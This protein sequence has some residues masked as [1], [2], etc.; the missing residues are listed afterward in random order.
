MVWEPTLS[1]GIIPT[2]KTCDTPF[3]QPAVPG[4]NKVSPNHITSITLRDPAKLPQQA[5][6]PRHKKSTLFGST[7]H[8]GTYKRQKRDTS[9]LKAFN[10]KYLGIRT[11]DI[12][13]DNRGTNTC[14]TPTVTSE[15][16][17][18]NLAQ[19]TD[20]DLI[21]SWKASL[22]TKA[23][24]LTDK[25]GKPDNSHSFTVQASGE[26][27]LHLLF[28][29]GYLDKHTT[30]NLHETH[31]LVKHLDDMRKALSNYDFTWIRDIDSNWSAQTTISKEKSRAMMACLLH[32][33]MDISLLMRYLGN[34]YT[35]A[36]RH[37]D[38][39]AIVETRPPPGRCSFPHQKLHFT[40]LPQEKP[41]VNY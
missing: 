32:Y 41:Y 7:F 4:P 12:V 2:S 25:F 31:P 37:R 20:S 6:N 16:P 39:E 18:S 26:T 11:D 40:A 24:L 35:A 22:P 10:K 17:V 19:S 9:L 21:P 29:S 3:S 14:D 30:A 33:D 5:K 36:H 15:H 28:K 8:K 27:A 34:N 23:S 13:I 38:V 1:T